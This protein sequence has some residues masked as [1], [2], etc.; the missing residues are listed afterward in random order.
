[1]PVA[2]DRVVNLQQRPGC[3]SPQEVLSVALDEIFPG[4][5]AVVSSFGAES[6]VLLHLVAA[7]D[8]ATPVVFVDTGRHFKETFDYRDRLVAYLGLTDVRTVGPSSKEVAR[9]DPDCS[10]ASWDSRRLLQLSNGGAVGA[11][12]RPV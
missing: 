1:M 6:A 4:R 5:I 8:S 7:V 12:S 11:L 3:A 2:T 9:L 10:R